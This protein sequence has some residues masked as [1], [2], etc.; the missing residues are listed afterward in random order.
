MADEAKDKA[1][2]FYLVIVSIVAIVA[3]VSMVVF[4]A[5]M[6]RKDSSA[7]FAFMPSQAS[8]LSQNQF[9]APMLVPV[10]NYSGGNGS[11]GNGSG[12]ENFAG[13]QYVNPSVYQYYQ[14]AGVQVDAF[15]YCNMY[16]NNLARYVQSCDYNSFNLYLSLA[17]IYCNS[18]VVGM[19]SW[20][21]PDQI[22]SKFYGS[23]GYSNWHDPYYTGV[24]PDFIIFPNI[25]EPR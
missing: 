21:S 7:Q 24:N 18:G 13:Y 12:D 20:Y 5:G 1:N 8:R 17:N 4:F 10:G 25:M 6:A 15:V 14:S 11:L 19:G 9:V 16:L 2:M 22:R 23:C 3:I